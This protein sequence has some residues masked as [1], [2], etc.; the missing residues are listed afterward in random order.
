[1]KL[2]QQESAKETIKRLIP[3]R[4][5]VYTGDISSLCSQYMQALPSDSSSKWDSYPSNLSPEMMSRSALEYMADSERLLRKGKFSTEDLIVLTEEDFSSIPM[6]KK[7]PEDKEEKEKLIASNEIIE[8]NGILSDSEKANLRG[9][10]HKL[11]AFG[12][13]GSNS[14]K[15]LLE[16][17]RCVR[18]ALNSGVLFENIKHPAI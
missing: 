3:T 5:E 6:I 17:K 12:P 16:M 9:Y 8:V 4:D 15:V 2:G 7:M 13:E 14:K 1:M 18:E 11:K 10:L